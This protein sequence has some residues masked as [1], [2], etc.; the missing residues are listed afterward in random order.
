MRFRRRAKPDPATVDLNLREQA[1]SITAAELSLA[2]TASQPHVWGLL[3]DIGYPEG[4]AT[5]VVFAE[6]TTSLYFDNG[7]GI[8]GGGEHASVRAAATRLLATAEAHLAMLA[9]APAAPLPAVGHVR[10]TLRTFE[11]T[12][13]AEASEADLVARRHPLS[14]LFS[15]THEVITALREVTEERDPSR[16]ASG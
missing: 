13:G 4:V 1:L 12:L 15:A 10:F 8:I 16:G 3:V 14:T 7:G 9:P 2:P 6:G 11:G 5:L